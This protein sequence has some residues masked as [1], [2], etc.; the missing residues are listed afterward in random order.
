M[1]L[2]SKA[3]R[4]SKQ[5]NFKLIVSVAFLC[6][7][8]RT[9]GLS[10]VLSCVDDMVA[11]GYKYNGTVGEY[12][13]ALYDVTKTN[14]GCTTANEK[15]VVCNIVNN[16]PDPSQSVTPF[17]APTSLQW[18]SRNCSPPILQV[19]RSR[20]FWACLSRADELPQ[21][22]LMPSTSAIPSLI[23]LL[24]LAPFPPWLTFE[25]QCEDH[26]WPLLNLIASGHL[27]RTLELVFVFTLLHSCTVIIVMIFQ[28][29]SNRT[30]M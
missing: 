19:V 22:I 27:V 2:A 30:R 5:W 21:A 10:N 20:S 16:V 4:S 18:L 12:F 1:T 29:Q 25:L 8:V 6:E 26:A 23:L 3:P 9:G 17:I 24:L 11:E 13:C 15:L 14:S 7:S 28:S